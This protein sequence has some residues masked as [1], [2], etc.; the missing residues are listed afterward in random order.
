MLGVHNAYWVTTYLSSM[1]FLITYHILVGI[2][3][4]DR[5]YNDIVYYKN[6]TQVTQSAGFTGYGLS[7]KRILNQ[8]SRDWYI[9]MVLHSLHTD[10][11]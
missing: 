4:N 9:D 6:T 1:E 7:K 5:A 8:W 2:I 11:T 10:T 3:C